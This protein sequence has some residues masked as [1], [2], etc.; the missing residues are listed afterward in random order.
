MPKFPFRL[1]FLLSDSFTDPEREFGEGGGV[2]EEGYVGSVFY[3]AHAE[4]AE[5]ADLAFFDERGAG[6]EDGAVEVL[7]CWEGQF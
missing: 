7:G 3:D 2:R 4:G 1:A 6:A 5:V